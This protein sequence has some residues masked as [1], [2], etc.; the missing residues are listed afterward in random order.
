MT[1]TQIQAVDP[2]MS[3]EDAQAVVGMM[4][5]V[6]ETPEPFFLSDEEIESLVQGI[7]QDKLIA[8]NA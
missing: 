7:E 6:T 3:L 5:S 1:T 4:S 8:Y 2:T